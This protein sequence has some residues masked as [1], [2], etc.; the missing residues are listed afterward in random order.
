MGN[1]ELLLAEEVGKTS[2]KLQ[3]TYALLRQRESELDLYKT[4]VE[5]LKTL[6]EKSSALIGVPQIDMVI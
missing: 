5:L 4:Q 1:H 3:D 2:M 6:Y